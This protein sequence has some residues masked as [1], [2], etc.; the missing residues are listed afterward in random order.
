LADFSIRE[1]EEWNERIEKIVQEVGL[2]YYEQEFEIIS[3]ED[4]MGYETYIGMPSHYPHW[5][6]GKAYERI[7]TLNRY[8]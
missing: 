4:M 3:Y 7:K 2:D 8:N 5:S 1:L 6:Y